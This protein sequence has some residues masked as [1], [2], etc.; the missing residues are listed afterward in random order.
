MQVLVSYDEPATTRETVGRLVDAG[1]N[2]IVLS[3]P[4]PCPRGVTRWPADEIIAGRH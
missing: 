4:R 1:M 2:H 3:L